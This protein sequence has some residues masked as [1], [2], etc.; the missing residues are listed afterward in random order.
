MEKNYIRNQIWATLV[1]LGL[2][3]ILCGLCYPGLITL[4]LQTA[5]NEKANGSLL[6][7]DKQ[8][9]GS[10]LIGQ[11]F[12]QNQY[13][14]SRP[15]ALTQPYDS[16]TSGGSNLNPTNP[17]QLFLVKARI[18]NLKQQSP[19]QNSLIPIDLVTASASGLDPDISLNAAWYQIPRIAK[20]RQLDEKDV[21][22]IINEQCP[23]ALIRMLSSAH[24]NVLKLNLALDK[25]SQNHHGDAKTG[26]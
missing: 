14:W 11:S 3:S 6:V 8:V 21:M 13:F 15:S 25:V 5:F 7:I 20:A 10:W 9:K 17:Q 19:T 26:S 12:T 4:L 16:V 24:V 18:E 2:S 22:G 1:F 23:N